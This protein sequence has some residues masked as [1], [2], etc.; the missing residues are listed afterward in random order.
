MFLKPL[1]DAIQKLKMFVGKKSVLDYFSR[2]KLY[3]EL[4]SCRFSTEKNRRI[5]NDTS[6]AIFCF[7]LNR[8]TEIFK[9]GTCSEVTGIL[10]L[11][12]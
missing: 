8:V 4:K 9:K 11:N 5:N 10:L 2:A 3:L 12:R 7:F 1:E 6:Y